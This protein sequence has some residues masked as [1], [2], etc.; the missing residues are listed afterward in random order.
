MPG[1]AI[2]ENERPRSEMKRLARPR[3]VV[4]PVGQ[5]RTAGALLFPIL[6]LVAGVIF[7][8]LSAGSGQTS[9]ATRE[10]IPA[11]P[12]AGVF[13]VQPEEP[14][15][16]A[17]GANGALYISDTRRD[18]ILQR[19]PRGLLTVLAGTGTPGFSGDGG[20]ARQAEIDDPGGMAVGGDGTVYFAD[21]G[22]NRVRAIAPDGKI[23][24]VAGDGSGGGAVPNGTLALRAPL[25]DPADVAI[26]PDGQLY[27]ADAGSDQVLRLGRGGRLYIVAGPAASRAA[28]VTGIGGPATRASPD[29]PDAIAFDGKGDLFIAGEN[30]KALLMVDPRG[31]MRLVSSRFYPRG[32]GGLV[33]GPHGVVYAMDTQ[34]LVALSPSGESAVYD[35]AGHYPLGRKGGAFLPDGITVAPDGTI[36]A[37]TDSGNGWAST[38]AIVALSPDRRLRVVWRTPPRRRLSGARQL[39][40]PGAGQHGVS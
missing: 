8:V 13:G 31:I 28:G 18:Q 29:G 19:S 14:G 5:L 40:H 23:S 17:L 22:N 20:P 27:I 21:Q 9:P 32:S 6:A 34:L 4:P 1:V 11:G 26:G 2:M 24:T 12:D 25:S 16:L 3:R 15:A 33:S 35:F 39:A 38:S 37:D 10:D 36:Y 30:T 7:V